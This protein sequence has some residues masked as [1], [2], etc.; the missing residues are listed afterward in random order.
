MIKHWEPLKQLKINE[1]D[2]L[3]FN[4]IWQVRDFENINIDWFEIPAIEQRDN[5]KGGG[6]IIYVRKSL[7]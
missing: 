7:S 3:L 4:E 6:V 1:Y 5:Q 2:V